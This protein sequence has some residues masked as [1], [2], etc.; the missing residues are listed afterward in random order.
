MILRFVSPVSH[1]QFCG[2]VGQIDATSR[3]H[4]GRAWRPFHEPLGFPYLQPAST[5]AQTPL[6]CTIGERAP[7]LQQ[8]QD[9]RSSKIPW[10]QVSRILYTLGCQRSHS[11]PFHS[12]QSCA[13]LVQ[14]KAGFS[15]LSSHISLRWWRIQECHMT[16]LATMQVSLRC[17]SSLFTP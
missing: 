6:T 2:C 3:R 8:T 7:L 12:L 16:K 11:Y 17:S 13:T 15:S 14:S 9:A 4:K 1:A 5:M 10:S